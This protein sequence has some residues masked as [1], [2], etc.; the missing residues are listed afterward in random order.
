MMKPR[1]YFALDGGKNVQTLA[2]Y[3]IKMFFKVVF[4]L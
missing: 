3:L 2:Q 4:Y 1:A